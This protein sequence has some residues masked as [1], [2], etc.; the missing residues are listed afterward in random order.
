MKKIF[1]DVYL[2]F[3]LGDDLFLDILAKKYPKAKFTVNYV[4]K[5]YDEF[6]SNYN[7]II[8]R[9]YTTINKIEQ[10]LKIK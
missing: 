4:G 8:R 3:N 6:I 10:K 1:V 7:N 9:K 5:D 2:A